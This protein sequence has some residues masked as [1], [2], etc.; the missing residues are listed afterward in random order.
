LGQSPAR[1]PLLARVPRWYGPL[2]PSRPGRRA[3]CVSGCLTGAVVWMTDRTNG[4]P[5]GATL[6]AV[7]AVPSTSAVWLPT[8]FA[9]AAGP[10]QE[11]TGD[12]VAVQGAVLASSA[13]WTAIWVVVELPRPPLSLGRGPPIRQPGRG[14]RDRCPSDDR[15]FLRLP[16][17]RDGSRVGGV[18]LAKPP[19]VG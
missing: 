13:M 17:G 11:A 9:L 14:N 16:H 10:L 1:D 8:P 4:L 6:V 15:V 3:R 19:S 18:E 5:V 12:L 7:L 2:Q